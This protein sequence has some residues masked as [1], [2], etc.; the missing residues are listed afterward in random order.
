M[1][2]KDEF[3]YGSPTER[4]HKKHVM[5]SVDM[6]ASFYAFY[7]FFSGESTAGDLMRPNRP[8]SRG[9]TPR[10]RSNAVAVLISVLSVLSVA[11]RLARRPFRPRRR[12]ANAPRQSMPSVHGLPSVA[13]TH[14]L[15]RIISSRDEQQHTVPRRAGLRRRVRE[16]RTIRSSVCPNDCP[17]CW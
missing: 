14:L 8:L 15:I 10:L 4:E 11:N 17:R 2:R 1:D 12:Q 9:Q 7:A 13:L 3:T 6:P 16:S 5:L